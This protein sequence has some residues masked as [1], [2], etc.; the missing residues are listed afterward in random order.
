M[1][2]MY[3]CPERPVP[4]ASGWA[5]QCPIC[6]G[7]IEY[8]VKENDAGAFAMEPSEWPVCEECNAMLEPEQVQVIIVPSER[9]AKIE[10]DE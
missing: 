8:F 9:S 3:E 2:R 10:D 5:I 1:S 6:Q 4:Y 7:E